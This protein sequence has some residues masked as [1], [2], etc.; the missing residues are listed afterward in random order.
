MTETKAPTPETAAPAPAAERHVDWAD[1]RQTADVSGHPVPR[2][3]P[4]DDGT[5][6]IPGLGVHEQLEERRKGER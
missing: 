2:T 4:A 6:H 5:T 3:K 1:G